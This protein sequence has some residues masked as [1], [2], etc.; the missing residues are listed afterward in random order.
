MHPNPELDKMGLTQDR[1]KR[2]GEQVSK[3]RGWI[4]DRASEVDH[5]PQM[6]IGKRLQDVSN[7]AKKKWQRERKREEGLNP[8]RPEDFK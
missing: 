2:Y 3:I 5:G 7:V 8:V 1:L 6:D 4:I